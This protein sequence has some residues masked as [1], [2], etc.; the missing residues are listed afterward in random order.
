VTITVHCDGIPVTLTAVD[1][2]LLTT[3]RGCLL[4]ALPPAAGTRAGDSVVFYAATPG[5]FRA[6]LEGTDPGDG[7]LG[8]LYLLNDHLPL[9]TELPQHR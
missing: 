9:V 3:A 6:L 8:G 7:G 5:A 4:L 2:G 1:P